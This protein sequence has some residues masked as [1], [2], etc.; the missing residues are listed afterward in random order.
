MSSFT[1]QEKEM[2]D[3]SHQSGRNPLTLFEPLADF[4][5]NDLAQVGGKGANLGELLQ[6]GFGVPPG[7]LITTAAY[8]LLV[9]NSGLQARLHDLLAALD[10]NDPGS[11]A[12]T[13]EKIRQ[14]FEQVPVPATVADAA[15]E[16]YRRL[17][18]AV[19]VRSSAP[20][21]DLPGAAFAGQQET[22]L[23]VLGEQAFLEAVRA[24]WISLWSERAVLYR[25][26]QNV[27]QA[28]VKLAVVV[29]QMV[30]AEV[31][32]VMF[33]ANPVSGARDELVIDASPGLGEAVVGGLVTP[34]HFV[35]DKRRQRVKEQHIGRREVII[36]A[37]TEGGTEQ[38]AP[39]PGQAPAAASLLPAALGKLARLG[40]AIE[41][42]YA[43][44][45]DIEWAWIADRTKAG[46]F[47]ILQARPMTAL[48][49]PLKVKLSRPMRQVMPMLAE[50]WPVRPYPLD[51]TTF[52]GT[53]ERAV[54]NLLVI[55]VGKS[56]P[57]PDKALLEEDG[58]VVR[59][60]PPEVRPSPDMLITPWLTF[61]HTRHYD[62]SHWQADPLLAEVVR[63]AREL[64]KRDL[65]Q[66]TWA[67]DI[68][69]IHEALAL[70]PHVMQLRERYLPQAILGLGSL[71]LLLAIACRSDRFGTLIGGVETKTTETNL[72]LQSLATQIR[73]DPTLQELF[74]H[75]EAGSMQSALGRSQSGQALLE[76]FNAFLAEYGHRETALTISQ[77]TWKDQPEIV[78][79]MLKV[80]AA[81]PPQQ[82]D[83]YQA[84][85]RV[86]DELLA[87]SILGRW[88]FRHLFLR[89]LSNGRALFQI[90]EDTH[91]Y[92]TLA[93]PLVRRV[94]L[95]LGRRLEEARVL[96]DAMDLVHLRLEGLEALGAP[97][98]PLDT[99]IAA[100]KTR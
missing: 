61:W 15:L 26:H 52:V 80:L 92:A 84:W 74:A 14:A 28:S 7:F 41:R 5:R 33:T 17:G 19:V 39:G 91:F 75:S 27:D 25:A 37:R 35:L 18:G 22:F 9:Q 58:V 71:W 31:A 67:Q 43:A 79:G 90:R 38:V 29:Q 56:A 53:L 59:F 57:D 70:I 50:M 72:A 36:R 32:G 98:P 49:E 85:K 64:E 21:E 20:A 1:P 54:G 24:C 66:L 99:A 48:P 16:A 89:V 45:Q 88:P 44:P 40:I 82:T 60:E 69:T 46:R 86:R 11:V 87:H 51:V 83:S 63:Q 100:T 65:R 73:G 68:E 55:M 6:A 97:W 95:E 8:D 94:A 77:G 81:T 3:P 13:S 10:P 2:S 62:P 93:L 96:Q 78:L 47:L 34:D 12:A 76:H 4:G 23:N 30:P 42:H